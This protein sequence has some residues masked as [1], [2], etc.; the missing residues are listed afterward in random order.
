MERKQFTFY[1]SYYEA[2]SLLPPEEQCAVILA[3]AAYALDET[4]PTLE[5]TAKAIFSLIRPTLDAGRKK[6]ESGQQGGSKTKAKPKQTKS[7]SKAKSKQTASEKEKEK[8]NEC[9]ISAQ[10]DA[11]EKFWKAYPKKEG[12]SVARKAFGNVKVPI[13]TLLSAVNRQKCNP[14]WNRDGGQYIP[15]A[16]TWLNQERWEDE[17]YS[18]AG[19]EAFPQDKPKTYYFDE[20]GELRV[21]ED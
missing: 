13:E 19:N 12:K 17:V 18:P 4:E 9:Y 2:I 8:E 5:G 6:A 1:R 11:F 3:V 16:S 15:L 14:Q 7:T 20:S 21:L 10:D